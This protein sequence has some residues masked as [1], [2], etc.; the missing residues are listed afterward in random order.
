[1]VV[2]GALEEVVVEE[3]LEV[4]G[5]EMVPGVRADSVVGMA[6][7]PLQVAACPMP[8]VAAEAAGWVEGFFWR[9][10]VWT[11][12]DAAFRTILPRVVAAVGLAAQGLWGET[13]LAVECSAAEALSRCASV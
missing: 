6:V 8:V 9:V 13:D 11:Y 5:L 2:R 1:M 7:A 12:R 3:E 10:G 4:L